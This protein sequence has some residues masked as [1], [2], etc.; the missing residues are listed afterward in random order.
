MGEDPPPLG[1]P[2]GRKGPIRGPLSRTGSR[3]GGGNSA[4]YNLIFSY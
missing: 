1:G 2:T 3:E 4:V